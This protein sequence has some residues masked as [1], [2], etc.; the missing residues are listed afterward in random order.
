M[1]S[2]VKSGDMPK[3]ATL[4]KIYFAESEDGSD[5]KQI[6]FCETVP[7]LEE[8]PEAITGSAVDID[9]EFSEPGKTKVGEIELSVYY[10]HTQHKWMKALDKKTGYFFVKHPE[11]TAPEGEEPL[12]RKF[13][14][15]MVTVPGEL[16]DEDWLKDVVKIFRNSAVTESYDKFPSEAV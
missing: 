1:A 16:A 15:S 5:A 8:V 12:L 10:T 3:L 11:S 4:S 13:S 14:G 9:Y 2:G 6:C 7:Q